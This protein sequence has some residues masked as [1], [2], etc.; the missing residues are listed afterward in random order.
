LGGLHFAIGISFFWRFGRGRRRFGLR[1]G[2]GIDHDR[3]MR[4]NAHLAHD[5]VRQYADKFLLTQLDLESLERQ[6]VVALVRDYL[7]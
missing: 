4:G 1:V 7:D 5:A 6:G 2:E 3:R